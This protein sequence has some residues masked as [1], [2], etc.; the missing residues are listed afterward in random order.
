VDVC[1]ILAY[2][3]RFSSGTRAFEDG[4]EDNDEAIQ[5]LAPLSLHSVPRLRKDVVDR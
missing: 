4:E 5:E 2:P 3:L 1:E